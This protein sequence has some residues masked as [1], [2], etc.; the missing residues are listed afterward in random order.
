MPIDGPDEAAEV[1]IEL[2]NDLLGADRWVG[3][4]PF[5]EP[6]E[7]GNVHLHGDQVGLLGEQ[8]L[9]HFGPRR[10]RSRSGPGRKLARRSADPGM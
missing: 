3:G 6:R 7:P 2:G 4:E 10:G 9:G 8:P 5:G 1:A